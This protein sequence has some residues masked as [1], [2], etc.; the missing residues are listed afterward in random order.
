MG[1]AMGEEVATV[2]S[3]PAPN[4]CTSQLERRESVSQRIFWA[5]WIHML[6]WH[7]LLTKAHRN[8]C[9]MPPKSGHAIGHG[10]F[11]YSFLEVVEVS[12]NINTGKKSVHKPLINQV[13]RIPFLSPLF[14]CTENWVTSLD[15][16]ASLTIHLHEDHCTNHSSCSYINSYVGNLLSVRWPT[17]STLSSLL[18][19]SAPEGDFSQ[20]SISAGI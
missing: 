2:G 10:S 8:N 5:V 19:N 16:A 17:T 12:L 14:R 20:I 11:I 9:G 13:P 18:W 3:I 6:F 1:W 15:I 4:S 7:Q